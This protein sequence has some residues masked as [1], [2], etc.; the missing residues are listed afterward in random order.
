[1]IGALIMDGLSVSDFVNR[2]TMDVISLEDSLLRLDYDPLILEGLKESY[3]EFNGY[4]L[5]V[6]FMIKYLTSYYSHLK[7]LYKVLSQ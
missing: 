2:L 6:E 4:A 7:E 5:T 1:M 3:L